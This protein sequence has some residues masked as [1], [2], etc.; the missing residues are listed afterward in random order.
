MFRLLE[1]NE[2]MYAGDEWY[3]TS[4]GWRTIPIPLIGVPITQSS[5][6]VRR[7]IEDAKELGTTPNRQSAKCLGCEHGF[8][9]IGCVLPAEPGSLYCKKYYKSGVAALRT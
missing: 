1:V 2:Q 9:E 4:H 5:S 6:P 3:D 8:H 7:K